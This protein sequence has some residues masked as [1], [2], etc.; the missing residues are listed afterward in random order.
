MPR[1]NR[2]VQRHFLILFCA[3]FLLISIVSAVAFARAGGGSNHEGGPIEYL[4][5]LILAPLLFVF[6]IYVNNQI[7]AK[8]TKASRLL[9]RL[10]KLDPAWN[11][12][13]LRDFV[14]TSFFQI[15]K[16]WCN[17]DL[18]CL[19]GLLT[20]GL[21]STWKIQ[22]ENDRSKGHRNV[23]ED[24]SLNRIRIV[25]VRN[26]KDDRKDSFTVC[27]DAVATDYVVDATGNVVGS[28]RRFILKS[29]QITQ[30]EKVA[31]REFWTYLRNGDTWQLANVASGSDW[32]EMV[33]RALLDEDQTQ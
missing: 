20:P 7:S 24:L 28:N 18:N 25:L 27:L 31:F 13:H 22:I 19:E 6:G 15:Q 21:F 17:Q 11:E 8:A 10:E 33:D 5:T 1:A 29:S 14:R 3:A 26:Y 9:S 2:T 23:M 30:K 16:A 12:D 32:K 4:A